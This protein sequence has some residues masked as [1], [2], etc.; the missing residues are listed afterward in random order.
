MGPENGPENGT[1]QKTRARK[2]DGPNIGLLIYWTC[3]VFRV[4]SCEGH[5]SD[6]LGRVDWRVARDQRPKGGCAREDGD[7]SLT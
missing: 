6:G 4:C 7:I 3:P 5:P 1:N 2:R